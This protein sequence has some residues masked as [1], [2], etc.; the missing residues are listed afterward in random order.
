LIAP[1]TYELLLEMRAE[2][3]LA[4]LIAGDSRVSIKIAIPE[5]KRAS[6]VLQ[7]ISDQASLPLADVEAAAQKAAEGLPGYA[8]SNLE[9]F[10][11]P[12][13]YT[14]SPGV[15]ADEIIAEMLAKHEAVVAE[16]GLEQKASE[17]GMTPYQ[18]LT[19]ASLLEV[20]AHPRD[21]A[22]VA[23]VV[24]N[25]LAEPMRLQFDS[26]VNYGLGKTAVILTTAELETPTAYNTY[27]N[28]GLPPTPIGNP[29]SAAIEAALNPAVGDWLYFITIDL[30]SQETAFTASYEEFLGF[31]DDFLAWCDAHPGSC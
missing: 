21:F 23:R 8:N 16:L 22:K 3:A 9:G 25:R 26:T 20:E 5:G 13:T 18:I 4:L 19:V 10:L 12:A 1:G 28:D 11:H 2:D 6:A 29:G 31:K 30:E 14:F 17:L 15:T 27:L 7:L 24:Y